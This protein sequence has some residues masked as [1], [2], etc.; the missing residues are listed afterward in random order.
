MIRTF[1][2]AVVISVL[3][4]PAF[5]QDVTEPLF[6]IE[7]IEVRNAKRVSPDVVI[8]ESLLREGHAYTETDLSDAAARLGRLPFLLSAEFS[9]DKGNDR[10]QYVLV[11]TIEETKPF[12]FLID[13]RPILSG[14]AG[15]IDVDYTDRLGNAET[16]A[17]LGFRWFV[18]RRGAV[19]VGLST[20]ND[21]RDFTRDH[22]AVVAGYTQYDVFGTRAF[23]TLNLKYP[24]E[25]ANDGGFSPQLVAGIPVSST[26]TVTLTYDVT[27]FGGDDRTVFNTVVEE[28]DD[29]QLVSARWSFNTTNDPFVPTTGVILSVTPFA[30]WRDTADYSI[31]RVGLPPGSQ[32]PFITTVD[33]YSLHT[34]SHGVDLGATRWFELTE[35]DSVVG[36]IEGGWA[37]VANRSNNRI[38]RGYDST[39]YLVHGGFSHSLWTRDQQKK[40][41][42]SRIE[43]TL[44]Y[45]NRNGGERRGFFAFQQDVMQASASW[46]RRSSWGTFRLGAGYAW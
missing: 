23:V 45:V 36:G 4:A 9:L 20:R 6:F 33:A 38:V 19:H 13:A 1:L 5:A 11:I 44:R 27:Q 21:N 42:D 16:Q 14:N 17:A 7:R 26:Q 32:P 46:V 31:H 22:S 24:V 12:F 40:H 2:I 15:I 25:P 8:A 30:A 37:Q 39:Y 29:E 3:A 18:G 34:N 41:G 28:R 10:G 35:R 43:A